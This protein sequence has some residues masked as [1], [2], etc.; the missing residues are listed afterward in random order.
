M[1]HIRNKRPI[2]DRGVPNATHGVLTH[3]IQWAL[4]ALEL[5]TGL[6]KPLSI[7]DLYAGL[8][9]PRSAIKRDSARD[10]SSISV[11]EEFVSLWNV[12]VDSPYLDTNKTWQVCNARSPE[13]LMAYLQSHGNAG[14][15]KMHEFSRDA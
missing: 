13:F 15:K 1:V 2:N 9:D 7:A 12:L 8:A 6:Q 14:L 5:G 10:G 3:R 11:G 4:C